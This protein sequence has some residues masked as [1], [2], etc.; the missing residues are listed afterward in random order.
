MGSTLVGSHLLVY[1]RNLLKRS[2]IPSSG[3]PG[4]SAVPCRLVNLMSASNGAC[5]VSSSGKVVRLHF[6][7]L[8]ISSALR[9]TACPTCCNC[10][11]HLGVNRVDWQA[12][13]DRP[14]RPRQRT[15]ADSATDS[16]RATSSHKALC[17]SLS[18]ASMSRRHRQVLLSWHRSNPHHSSR[19]P[20][21]PPI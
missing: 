14:L 17:S 21:S 2:K 8:P 4:I 10:S 12:S 11:G 20:G 3:F 16:F 1:V 15:C 19:R 9:S 7:R 6:G 5:R 13:G 18:V